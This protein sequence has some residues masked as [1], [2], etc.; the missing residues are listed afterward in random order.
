MKAMG[1]ILFAIVAGCSNARSSGQ[2]YAERV[3]TD[4]AGYVCFVVRDEEAKAVGGNCLR[5]E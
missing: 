1:W 5:E 2:P 4:Q 3:F